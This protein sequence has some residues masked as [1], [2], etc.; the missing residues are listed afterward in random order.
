ML[1]NFITFQLAVE[2]HQ[3]CA[4]VAGHSSFRDQ[5]YRASLS[6]AINL[7][8]GS[9]KPSLKE[10]HRFYEIARGSLRET[11]ALLLISKQKE[12]EKKADK[13]GAYLHN[14]IKSQQ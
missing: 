4:K 11:Q 6:V 10:K 2:L 13:L 12:L 5:L 7:A 14:L 9:D 3:A 1:K 8:E